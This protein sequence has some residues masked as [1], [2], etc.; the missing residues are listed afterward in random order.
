MVNLEE[1]RPRNV[2]LFK[3]AKRDEYMTPAR[4]IWFIGFQEDVDYY[5]QQISSPGMTPLP[6]RFSI[7]EE[8]SSATVAVAAVV[9]YN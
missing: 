8:R 4:V 3:M 6:I 2:E 9:D 7:V 5:M 1:T